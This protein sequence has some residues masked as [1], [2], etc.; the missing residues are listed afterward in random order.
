MEVGDYTEADK[1]LEA[2]QAI[3][4]EHG[5]DLKQSNSR[6]HLY[7]YGKYYHILGK[8]KSRSYYF[9]K[10]REIFEEGVEFIKEYTPE[11]D[12]AIQNKYLCKLYE[13]QAFLY[14]EPLWFEKAEEHLD[15]AEALYKEKSD[16][17][18]Q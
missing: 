13:G 16:I 1:A 9:E 11:P 8:N 3:F 18:Y 5:Q 12:T 2:V 14:C 10:A 15:K 6:L 17:P 4:T 7:I